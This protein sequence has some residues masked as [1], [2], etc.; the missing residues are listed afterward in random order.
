MPVTERSS[1]VNMHVPNHVTLQFGRHDSVSLSLTTLET[2]KVLSITTAASGTHKL[3]WNRSGVLCLDGAPAS[4]D[5]CHLRRTG[6][7]PGLV[8]F[9]LFPI[10]AAAPTKGASHE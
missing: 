9:A 8:E 10:P 1:A 6:K 3:A 7:P 2:L 4:V 5:S